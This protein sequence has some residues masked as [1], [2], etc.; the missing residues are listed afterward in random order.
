VVLIAKE[1]KMNETRSLD[2]WF[3]LFAG[4]LIIVATAYVGTCMFQQTQAGV[5]PW[6]LY[7]AFALLTG[8]IFVG[9]G[10]ISRQ[11]K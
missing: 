4:L 5:F 10:F 9:Y 2:W 3:G 11:R 8:L 1:T 7:P 6:W